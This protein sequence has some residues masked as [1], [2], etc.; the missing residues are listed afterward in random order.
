MKSNILLKE[1]NNARDYLVMVE[2]QKE[3][4][5]QIPG[6]SNDEVP[7]ID[8]EEITQQIIDDDNMSNFDTQDAIDPLNNNDDNTGITDKDPFDSLGNDDYSPV[9]SSEEPTDEE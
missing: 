8:P 9:H 2:K 4:D 7:F 1:F 3:I 6:T 5:Y